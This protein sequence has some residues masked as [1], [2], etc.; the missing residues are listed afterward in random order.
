[1][2][3][4][5]ADRVA[6]GI[7]NV[8]EV[9]QVEVQHRELLSAATGSCGCLVHRLDEDTPIRQSGQDVVP[10]QPQDRLFGF[11]ALGDIVIDPFDFSHVAAIVANRREMRREPSPG[12]P[13]G[14]D[15]EFHVARLGNWHQHTAQRVE[16][17]GLVLGAHEILDPFRDAC[18]LA[19]IVAGPGNVG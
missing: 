6:Q 19:G 7:V 14:R 4:Q 2:Q 12:V 5:I 10:R 1:M 17:S 3:Q 13:T 11:L 8:L 15:P 9:V 16:Q 18:Y